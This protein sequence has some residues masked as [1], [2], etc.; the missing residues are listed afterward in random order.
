VV[1]LFFA[2]CFFVFFVPFVFLRYAFTLS[3]LKPR[4]N[5]VF[6]KK[7][8]FKMTSDTSPSQTPA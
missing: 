7:P 2:L 5:R 8:G 4:R 1:M 3:Y 6:K